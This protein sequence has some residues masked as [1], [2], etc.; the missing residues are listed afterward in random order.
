M[1]ILTS[2][3]KQARLIQIQYF[4]RDFL[5]FF[6]FFNQFV[7]SIVIKKQYDIGIMYYIGFFFSSIIHVR[8]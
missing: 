4:Q 8:I 7:G 1:Y 2:P 5:S 6:F 3:P